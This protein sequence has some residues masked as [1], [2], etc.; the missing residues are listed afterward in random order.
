MAQ[1]TPGTQSGPG[2]T[3]QTLPAGP[4][5]PARSEQLAQLL[6]RFPAC[7]VPRWRFADGIP[8]AAVPAEHLVE[9]CRWLMTE[10]S[11]PVDVL[12]D[13][14]GAHWPERALPFEVSYIFHTLATNARLRL[15]CSAGADAPALP[16]LVGLWPAAN[17]PEREIYDMF[18]VTFEGHPDL[19]RILMPYDWE[20]HPLRKDFPL[21]EEAVEFYRPPAG[22]PAST[23]AGAE[24]S[25]PP[26]AGSARAL[27]DGP[28]AERGAERG[29]Q[30]SER[31]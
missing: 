16:S 12:V 25:A 30:P 9:V 24:V 29:G 3:P 18:G 28:V 4:A 1:S 27:H 21:G 17:W 22:G 5:A 15:K 14:C 10:A 31:G 7:T 26:S 20:G 13:V 19:R 11:P 2:A 8:T 23:R 6:E